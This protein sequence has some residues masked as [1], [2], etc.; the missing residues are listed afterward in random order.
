MIEVLKVIGTM[1][2]VSFES[3]GHSC[4]S[5]SCRLFL[6]TNLMLEGQHS[7]PAAGWI[8]DK[9]ELPGGD[10][11]RRG[12]V[13]WYHTDSHYKWI[14]NEENKCDPTLEKKKMSLFF[15]W[16]EVLSDIRHLMKSTDKRCRA[17]Y[18]FLAALKAASA[19]FFFFQALRR[20]GSRDE[21]DGDR[22]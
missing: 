3:R 4:C 11:N 22:Q 2:N 19:F 6:I 1:L 8:E 16:P 17:E 18:I 14:K 10:T 5:L 21:K 12:E 13:Y 15:F 9:A 7:D 20:K